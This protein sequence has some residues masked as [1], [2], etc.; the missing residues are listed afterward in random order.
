[1]GDPFFDL[2]NFS[3]NHE[4]TPEQDGSSS[5]PTTATSARHDCADPAHAGRVHSAGHVGVLQQGI[6]TPESTV[7]Y[8]ATLTGPREREHAE[9][10]TGA[11]R[12]LHD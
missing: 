9:V 10:R 4:L 12:R 2:G 6:S 5:R 8:A 7:A 11:A 1:M 3:I